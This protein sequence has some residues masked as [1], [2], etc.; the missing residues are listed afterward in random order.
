MVPLSP[1]SSVTQPNGPAFLM[2]VAV[3]RCVLLLLS[4]GGEKGL[5]VDRLGA[6]LRR[7]RLAR[8]L[9]GLWR[10]NTM[11]KGRARRLKKDRN[12]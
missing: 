1:L 12:P 8:G 11:R 6:L 4:D 9:S 10:R 7:L 3:L 2:R 5:T